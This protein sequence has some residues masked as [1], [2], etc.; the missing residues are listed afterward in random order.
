MA[1]LIKK[2]PSLVDSGVIS[3]SS[4]LQSYCE[5][6]INGN[7]PGYKMQIGD[8]IYLAESGYAI[9]AEGRIT[10]TRPLKIVCSLDELF[11]YVQETKIKNAKYWFSIANE[12]I[13]L[14]KDKFKYLAIFEYQVDRCALDRPIFL[15]SEFRGQ[16]S[17]Y[18]LSDGYEFDEPEKNF[19]LSTKIPSSLRLHLFNKWNVGYDKPMIDI[20]HFVPSSLGGPGNIEENLELVGL[21]I[22][23]R[24]GN[25]AP[26]GVFHVGKSFCR[27]RNIQDFIDAQFLSSKSPLE[28]SAEGKDVAK[29]ITDHVNSKCNSLNDIRK[30]YSA[31]KDFHRKTYPNI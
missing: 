29:K 20:D 5:T 14:K 9:Y 19:E 18:S 13:F 27:E 10:A 7:P 28:D 23:R 6:R 17:Y 31:V 8:K 15:P 11:A 26:R 24:K 1:H 4:G 22:N 25:S 30:F 12:K 3:K 21:S 16:S 2:N